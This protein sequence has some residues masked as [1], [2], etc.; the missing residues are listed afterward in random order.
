MASLLTSW[1]LFDKHEFPMMQ[2]HQNTLFINEYDV[3]NAVIYS[4]DWVRT[5]AADAGL[6]VFEARPPKIRGFQW[7]LRM[8]Q[9]RTASTRSTGRPTRRR[10]VVRPRR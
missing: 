6:A 7:E 9:A 2:E 4:R 10:S 1:F 3:R 5:A 8:T